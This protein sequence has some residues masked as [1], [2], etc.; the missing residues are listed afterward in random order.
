MESTYTPKPHDESACPICFEAIDPV[1]RTTLKCSHVYCTQ[2]IINLAK[3]S[4]K[5]K[6][7]LCR[8]DTH[9]K[10]KPNAS[11]ENTDYIVNHWDTIYSTNGQLECLKYACENSCPWN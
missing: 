6:C 7:A 3:H 2:C 4:N 10:N 5:F 11:Q 1:A 8:D 9:E